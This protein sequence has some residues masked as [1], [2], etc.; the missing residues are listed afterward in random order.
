M[1]MLEKEGFAYEGYVDIFDGGPTMLARTDQVVSV[2]DAVEA[3]IAATDIEQGERAII[4]AGRLEDFRSCY[5]L[6]ALDADRM[7]IDAAAARTLGIANGD[8]AWSVAR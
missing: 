5:G 7:A 2:R 4:A 6:R 1:R 3:R 8:T